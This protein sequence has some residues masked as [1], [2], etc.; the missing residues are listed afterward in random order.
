VLQ[1]QLQ[2][3]PFQGTRLTRHLLAAAKKKKKN[4]KKKAN[5]KAADAGEANGV[6]DQ[7]VAGE[8]EEDDDDDDAG[9][10]TAAVC[11]NMDAGKNGSNI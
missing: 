11:A 9:P 8:E 3:N 1:L 4:N 7:P 10:E 6:K 5:G 2:R